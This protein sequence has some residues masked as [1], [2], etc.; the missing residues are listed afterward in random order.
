MRDTPDK[1]R[2]KLT[3]LEWIPVWRT[4]LSV[5]SVLTGIA[6]I[7]SVV[8]I[9]LAWVF[10]IVY[11]GHLGIVAAALGATLTLAREHQRTRRQVYIVGM[12][13]RDPIEVTPQGSRSNMSRIKRD[14]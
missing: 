13:G 2:E 1:G 6:W 3:G 7:A 11:L 9:V 10:D 12:A 5:G 14:S 8:L 4:T